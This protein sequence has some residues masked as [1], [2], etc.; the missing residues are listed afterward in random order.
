MYVKNFY[1]NYKAETQ[2]NI[3]KMFLLNE[4]V[5][6]YCFYIKLKFLNI[7]KIYFFPC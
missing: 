7:K 4:F 3:N 2:L 1:I 6:I 5:V